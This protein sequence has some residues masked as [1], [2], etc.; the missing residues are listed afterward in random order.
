M[1]KI[2]RRTYSNVGG[3]KLSNIEYNDRYTDTTCIAD[4]S[5]SVKLLV[6]RRRIFQFYF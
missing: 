4:N 3:E 5:I 6:F 2:R 1:T